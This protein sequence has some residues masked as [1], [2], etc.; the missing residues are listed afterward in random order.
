MKKSKEVI[1]AL[2]K[3][4]LKKELER[5]KQ[6]KVR[7]G[8]GTM[9]GR[10]YK[11]KVGVL[12]VAAKKCSLLKSAANISGADVV[13]VKNLN[14][15]LLAP[16]MKTGRTTVWTKAAIEKLAKERLFQ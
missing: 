1:I 7:A 11:R 2:N 9:R 5:A 16:G 3:I 4:G 13:E 6:K 12:V 15:A 14:A 10:K 8:R